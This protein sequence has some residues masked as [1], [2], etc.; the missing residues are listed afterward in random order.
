MSKRV[1]STAIGLFIVI[2]LA[3]GVS[4]LLLFSSSRLFSHTLESII[5]FNHSLN[6]LN[7]GAPV[8]YRGVTIG[9]VKR[10]MVRFNQATND[11]A[12][13]V[14]VEL[15]PK[16]IEERLGEPADVFTHAA[17]AERIQD[18]MRASLQAVSLLTGVLYIDIRPNPNAAPPVFHQLQPRY[19]EI[20][21]ESTEIQQLFNTLASLD[22][23]S[24]ETNLNGLIRKL[25]VM[26]GTVQVGEIQKGITNVLS[27]VDRLVSS[28]EI[29][30]D[31]VALHATLDQ[32]RLLAQKL[33]ARVDP[34]ADSLT[35]VLAQASGTLQQFR[36][37][38]EHLRTMLAPDSS[39]R[40]ELELALQQLGGTAQSISSLAEFLNRHPNALI[41]GREKPP[42]T[43]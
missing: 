8:K 3:L 33:N 18:G 41:V 40:N 23:K 31:L 28:P 30:N 7:E 20:P 22:I 5:Y 13:P 35:N 25:D 36:G 21:S 37:V 12:M 4:G 24:I 27:S 16:L 15:D 32:Y 26:I 9:S 38:G 29:T 34:L 14:V 42:R 10:V 39:V 1:S 11:Y 2:G 43:P 17:L 6:G 19:P